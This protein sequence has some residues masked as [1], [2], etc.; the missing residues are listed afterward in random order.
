VRSATC[1][2]CPQAA[3][4]VAPRVFSL[5]VVV[6]RSSVPCLVHL[7]IIFVTFALNVKASC[8]DSSPVLMTL[9]EALSLSV[10]M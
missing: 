7:F 10:L 9:R 6:S 8:C 3:L 1:I 4:S 2:Q 5:K